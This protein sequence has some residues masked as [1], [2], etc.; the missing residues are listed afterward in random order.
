MQK[1]FK[2]N[3]TAIIDGIRTPDIRKF[4]TRHITSIINLWWGWIIPKEAETCRTTLLPKKDEELDEVGNWRPIT[5]GN[6]FMRLYAKLWDKRLMLDITLGKRQKGFLPV[7]R[8]FENV[9]ILKQTIKQLRK[10]G[11]EHNLV[12]INLAKAFDTVS[13]NSIEKGL[14]RKGITEQVRKTV[15]EMYRGETEEKR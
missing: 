11:K 15:M 14:R 4:P 9:K 1:E 7:N 10:K 2:R 8:F 12:F 5:I 6:L 13:H 3:T